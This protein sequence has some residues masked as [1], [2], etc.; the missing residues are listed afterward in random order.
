M[1]I[2]NALLNLRELKELYSGKPVC[3]C[4]LY[5][6]SIGV[7][8]S[9]EAT[10]NPIVLPEYKSL[11]KLNVEFLPKQAGSGDPSPDNVR[12]ISG[13]DS[14]TVTRCGNNLLNGEC[15]SAIIFNKGGTPALTNYN[16]TTISGLDVSNLPIHV[17]Q[18]LLGAP[19][20]DVSYKNG[21]ISIKTP[22]EIPDDTE[23]V[24]SLRIRVTSALSHELNHWIVLLSGVEAVSPKFPVN[25]TSQ[26]VQTI[27]LSFKF[28]DMN[29]VPPEN[30]LKQLEFRI[31]GMSFD[32]LEIQ[33]EVGSTPTAYEPHQGETSTLTLP[34]TI[35]GGT[36]DAISGKGSKEWE[37]V[38]FDG[39][40]NWY[41]NGESGYFLNS[42]IDIGPPGNRESISNIAVN[43]GNAINPIPDGQFN[44][45]SFVS[46][47]GWCG[48]SLSFADSLESWKSYLAAQ[49]SAGTPVQ[50]AYKLATPEPFEISKIS[51]PSLIG[52]NT[53]FTNGE[54]MDIIY[55]KEFFWGDEA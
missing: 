6:G 53:F 30:R 26:E 7:S 13:Y 51:I 40:E 19:E 24:I 15:V 4:P 12:A 3:V 45:W 20:D 14:V 48:F 1:V 27:T 11:V 16:G 2:F 47:R 8:K 33:L 46:Q 54:N 43:S 28:S 29:T 41:Q 9:F 23:M 37:L 21:Y 55:K 17:E 36:V 38:E 10:G 52:E 22:Q 32:I 44:T 42:V 5:N 50:V 34:E 31:A 39:T 49:A 18:A 25:P 35:Y